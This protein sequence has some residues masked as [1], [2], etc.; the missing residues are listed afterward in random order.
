MNCSDHEVNIKILL[1][2]VVTD[3]DLTRKQ[4]NRLLADMTDA[5]A[6]RVLRGSYLQT[7]ALSLA[8]AQAPAMLDVHDR[9]MRALEQS[10]RLDRELEVLPEG[11]AITDRRAAHAGLT[12]PE[13][14][15]LLAYSKITLYA[16]L[17]DSDLPEDPALTGE[18]AGYFPDPL[19][20][21]F[22][23]R[24]ERHR[25]RREIVAT[26]VTNGI[27]DRAG[28]TFVFRL[29]EDTG[30]SAAD[31]ARAYAVAR[32]VFD[33]RRLWADIE[34]LDLQVDATVQIEMLLEARRLV[35]RATRWLLRSRPRP[36][37]VGAEIER[38]A[39][40]AAAVG[41]AL[42]GVL[43]AEERDA[44]AAHVAELAERGVP[45]DLARRVACLSDHFAALDIV[46]VAGATERTIDEVA[47][48]HFLVGGRLSLHW[49]RDRIATLPREN[50]WQAMARAALRD[51]LF[52]LHAELTADVLR[53]ADADV[54]DAEA[55][56]DAW[57]ETNRPLVERC[58]GILTD[59]R[60]G[61]TYDLTT[62][63]VALARAPEPPPGLGGERRRTGLIAAMTLVVGYAPD[64]RG[65]AVLHLAG[66]LARSAQEDLVVCAVVPS[67]WPGESAQDDSEYR[68]FLDGMARAALE[69]ARERLP[70][71]VAAASLVHHARSAPAG[72][73]EVAERREAAMIVVGTSGHPAIGS[74]TAR[75]LHGS[76]VPVALAP[77][78][79][80]ARPGARVERVT[81]AFGG[82][83]GLV[84][85]AAAL[86]A[87]LGAPLRI[88]SFAVPAHGSFGAELVE[89][90]VEEIETAAGQAPAVVGHG[91]SWEEAIDD[92]EWRDGDVLVVGSSSAAPA[93]RVFLGSRASRI[94]RHSPVPVLVVPR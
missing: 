53:G 7:Q 85:A 9:M 49:L 1:D 33:M 71:D 14:A 24:L 10:G 92:V 39:A 66:M 37:D 83:E 21:R 89:R 76:P 4:R 20:E 30:A 28:T 17:L 6:E 70:G 50:R 34:A 45:E 57:T 58:H 16:E 82:S 63:P 43:V 22:A 93:A 67:P 2:A 19:P 81:A 51:D 73:L 29:Q 44:L 8:R 68:G 11:D 87:R 46:G 80:R 25:L 60:T 52:S 26:R 3:G 75:L 41:E 13:L 84:G 40:G 35:E 55:R 5:V 61:G 77:H 31:I 64:G 38:F 27:V 23:D 91:S 32:D 42:P 12:Q 69:R 65:G 62:L 47:S 78:A 59:I 36:L 15:V 90:W 18:L 88:A 56:L 86:A 72:L 48:L 54:V 94:I 74:V 79:F